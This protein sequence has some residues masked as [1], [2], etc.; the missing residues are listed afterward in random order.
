MRGAFLALGLMLAG[1]LPAHGFEV[2]EEASF[3]APGP[4]VA[5]LRVL[6]TTD[7]QIMA[8]VIAG[9]QAVNRGITIHYTV[10][11]SQQVQAAIVTDGAAY[12]LV[13]SSAMDLQMQLANDRFRLAVAVRAHHRPARLGALARHPVCLC[14]RTRRADRRTQCL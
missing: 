13:I 11:N 6:S 7:T 8:P 9:F 5:V 10:A 14:A 1:L 2:E 3:A 12:D 4:E